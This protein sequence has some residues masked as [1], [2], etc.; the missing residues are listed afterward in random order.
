M[1]RYGFLLVAALLAAPPASTSPHVSPHAVHV[2]ARLLPSFFDLHSAPSTFEVALR[3]DRGATS[4][5]D[6]SVIA[7]GLRVSRVGGIDLP[8]PAD[9][10]DALVETP[11]PGARLRGV[12][13]FSAP[14]DGDAATPDGN[15]ADLTAMLMDRPDGATVQVCFAGIADGEA[16]EACTSLRIRNQGLRK[17]PSRFPGWKQ[18]PG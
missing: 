16:F 15:G 6:P 8:G 12:A 10:A 7:A 9:G 4:P 2:Q 17:R 13:V 11:V 1:M 5:L 3:V 14:S 18:D